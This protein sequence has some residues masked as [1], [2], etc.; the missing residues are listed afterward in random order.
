MQLL[1]C[2]ETFDLQWFL[3]Y[4]NFFLNFGLFPRKRQENRC[5]TTTKI[6]SM[7][8]GVS[9]YPKHNFLPAYSQIIESKFFW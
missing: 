5:Q 3:S 2:V 4:D 9:F 6:K 7:C 8:I 1:T